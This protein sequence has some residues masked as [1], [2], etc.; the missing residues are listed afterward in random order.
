MVG[1]KYMLVG[2]KYMLVDF[3]PQPIAHII[4]FAYVRAPIVGRTSTA[5]FSTFEV[6]KQMIMETHCTKKTQI[7]NVLA[8]GRIYESGSNKTEAMPQTSFRSQQHT[9]SIVLL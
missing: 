6:K 7:P 8:I 9:L 1:S 4:F 5:K 3:A 2:S